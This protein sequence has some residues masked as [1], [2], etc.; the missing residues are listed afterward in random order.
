[1]GFQRECAA[2]LSQPVAGLP[3]GRLQLMATVAAPSLRAIVAH[4]PFPTWGGWTLFAAVAA[5][6][7]FADVLPRAARP[8]SRR[9]H[10]DEG[11][12]SADAAIEFGRGLLVAGAMAWLVHGLRD[13][14][15]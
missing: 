10:D 15:T 4:E 11:A 13:Q 8:H 3:P 6:D 2:M 12:R 1:M 9:P 7:D 5:T 14:S